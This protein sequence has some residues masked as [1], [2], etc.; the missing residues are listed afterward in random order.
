MKKGS[1]HHGNLQEA[2]LKKGLEMLS[3]QGQEKLSL[4]EAAR[5]CG[6]SP[7]AP[8]AHFKDKE[9]FLLALQEE[10]MQ[11]LTQRL[12]QAQQRHAGENSVLIEMGLSYVTFF[13]DHP[14]Y[15]SLMFSQ[16]HHVEAVLWNESS[17]QN[18]AFTAL[19]K[20]A[21][22][23]LTHFQIPPPRQHD[24]LLAMWAQVHGLAA[25]VCLPDIAARLR[26]DPL[27]AAR[28]RAI[29]TAFSGPPPRP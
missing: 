15:F 25:I 26:A 9:A 13:V 1:Y 12:R 14:H 16:S 22:P 23:I 7:T 29:L 5:Q 21:V 28:L 3:L 20:A 17:E 19:R 2:L 10:V 24:I 11:Q 27:A 6:V 4:R 18:P 8:F